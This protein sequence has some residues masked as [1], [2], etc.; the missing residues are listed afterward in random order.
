L[1]QRHIFRLYLDVFLRLQG[2]VQALGEAPSRHHAA[3][4]L[5][6]DDDFVVLDD[7]VLVL[8]EQLVRLQ[9]LIDVMNDRDVLDIV[10]VAGFQQSRLAQQFD[11][12]LVAGV[13]Q[14]H[15]TLFFVELVISRLARVPHRIGLGCRLALDQG[16]HQ[17]IDLAV[18]FGQVFR[19]ARYDQRRA[20]LIN[21]DGVHF[22][23]DDIGMPALG[24]RRDRV[25][26]VV[27]QIVEAEFVVGAVGDVAGVV[28][29][30]LL[31]G[32]AVDD[33]ADGQ[34][35]EFVDLAH[36]FGVAFGQIVVHGHDMDAF[37]G[38]CVQIDG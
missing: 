37:A 16:R 13:G 32:Q 29:V 31:V 1:G 15:L 3:G 22:I 23:D 6:D 27:A 19:R 34:A 12:V 38:Q 21:Q 11:H 14:S 18:Q 24:H 36:P 17:R 33:A 9:R 8:L 5:V 4:E 7:V 10:E 35:E 2:L 26:H 28:F 25:L 20:R 30:S